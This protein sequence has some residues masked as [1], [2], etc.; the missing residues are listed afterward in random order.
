MT[1]TESVHIQQILACIPP[2]LA[3]CLVDVIMG[4]GL[5]LIVLTFVLHDARFQCA[6]Y[7]W[8]TELRWE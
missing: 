6:V 3:G 7:V 1:T 8:R 4:I 2:S 5:A